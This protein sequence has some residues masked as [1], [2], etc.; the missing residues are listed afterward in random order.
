MQHYAAAKLEEFEC[1]VADIKA[2]WAPGGKGLQIELRAG[3]RSI[4]LG[5]VIMASLYERGS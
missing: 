2:V 4:L 1:T 3:S 5:G